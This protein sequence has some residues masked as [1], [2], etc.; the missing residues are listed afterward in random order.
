MSFTGFLRDAARAAAAGADDVFS[1]VS[2]EVEL[3]VRRRAEE[4]TRRRLERLA[5]ESREREEQERQERERREVEARMRQ[6]R[7][8]HEAKRREWEAEMLARRH[9]RL[10]A[11]RKQQER[12]EREQREVKRQQAEE[13]RKRVLKQREA[14]RQQAEEQRKRVLEQREAESLAAGRRAVEAREQREAATRRREE[15]AR[16]EQERRARKKAQERA[17]RL[18]CE[19]ADEIEEFVRQRKRFD[20][21]DPTKYT[22]ELQSVVSELRELVNDELLQ[23]NPLRDN[24]EPY[25]VLDILEMCSEGPDSWFILDQSNPRSPTVRVRQLTPYQG[26]ERRFGEYWCSECGRWWPSAGSWADKWQECNG[27]GSKIYP[28]SQR[29]L[30]GGG[31]RGGSSEK[32]HDTT[33]CEMCIELGEL[34]LR[35]SECGG[36][37]P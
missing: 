16:E 5:A 11:E 21:T 15:K 9:E 27:C 2:D 37:K 13:Q 19:C 31:G 23:A 14:E 36:T 8:D 7:E 4:R 32:K 29:E 24:P 20:S 18:L 12:R 28:F 3:W 22:L 17:E 26:D 25:T 1:R 30:G 6:L 10:A 34:C 35:Y 33:G